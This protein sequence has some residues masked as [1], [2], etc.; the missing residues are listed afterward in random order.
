M[1]GQVNKN[2]IKHPDEMKMLDNIYAS[3]ADSKA[4][5]G[6]QTSKKNVRVKI[7]GMKKRKHQTKN[8][9]C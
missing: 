2:S 8:E 1:R 5:Y 6:H 4:I 7:K 3:R 9:K